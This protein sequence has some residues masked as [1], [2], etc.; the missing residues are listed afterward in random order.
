MIEI[1]QEQSWNQAMERRGLPK[2]VKQMGTPDAGD[3]IYIENDA[4]QKIHTRAR[5]VD[6]IVYVLMGHFDNFGGCDC[7]F[8]ED[9]VEMREVDFQGN[10][11]IWTDES[12]KY[13]YRRLRPEHENMVIVGWAVDICGQLPGMSAQLEHIHQSYF[14]GRQ[15]VLMLLDSLEHEEVFYGNQNGYLKRRMGFYICYNKVAIEENYHPYM[16][17]NSSAEQDAYYA[18]EDEYRRQESYREYLNQRR[19]QERKRHPMHHPQNQ[20]SFVSTI[21]L[22]LVIA[23]LGYSAIQNQR[24]A[25][26]IEQA[27]AQLAQTQSGVLQES[28]ETVI[29][30]EEIV[31]SI[32]PD[33]D[34]TEST[35]KVE[36]Q[37]ETTQNIWD[38]VPLET[39]SAQSSTTIEEQTR[40]TVALSESERYLKQ[41]YYI[42][43]SGDN[44]AGICQ[45]IYHSS[46]MMDEVCR[47]NGIENP[48]AIYAGQYLELP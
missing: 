44:L 2:S 37:T 31:G 4:Y 16:N 35:Q 42:V 26:E 19:L 18:S 39:E 33:T 41:G 48:D 46:A 25:N 11:P 13:L 5:G 17:T 23:A 38:E 14:G 47:I 10:L 6:R 21:L 9:A 34:V 27:L 32:A 8:V 15:Q 3:R 45:K 30:V 28:D 7:T 40:E 1:I 22:V 36:M 24:K 20:G 29:R 43:Q 12:W